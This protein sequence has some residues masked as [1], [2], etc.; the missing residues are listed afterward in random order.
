[1]VSLD[2]ETRFK[3]TNRCKT[4]FEFK[5]RISAITHLV[6]NGGGKLKHAIDAEIAADGF[7]FFVRHDDGIVRVFVVTTFHADKRH[8]RCPECSIKSLKKKITKT[9]TTAVSE[10]TTSWKLRTETKR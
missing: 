3:S 8:S 2:Q 1:M 7:Q 10:R 6:S 5:H 9:K 4:K